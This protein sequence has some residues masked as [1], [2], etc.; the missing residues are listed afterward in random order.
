ME[1]LRNFGEGGFEHPKPPPPRYATVHN[2]SASKSTL[3]L[4]SHLWSGS[5]KLPF[6]KQIY[7][8]TFRHSK[9]TSSPS[10]SNFVP[11]SHTSAYQTDLHRPKPR[12]PQTSSFKFHS[13]FPPVFNPLNAE[14]NP[15]CHLLELLGAHHIFHVSGLWVKHQRTYSKPLLLLARNTYLIFFNPLNAKL[16]PICHL[17]ALLGA[18]HIFHVSGLWVKHQRTYSKP[19]LLL[20]RNTYFISF[21]PLNAKLNPICHLLALLGAHHIFHVSRLWVKHQRTY[22]KPLLLL[23]RNTYLIFFNPL[24]AKLNPNCHLLALLGAH[25]IL[26]VSRIRVNMLVLHRPGPINP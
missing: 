20:A 22:S 17:L 4:S 3:L 14:L 11:L 19:L 24:K 1:G 2:P 21:N 5:F 26:H 25:H 16:N 12:I 23:A 15:I 10:L 13:K 9:D 18:H 7:V 8:S 6:S